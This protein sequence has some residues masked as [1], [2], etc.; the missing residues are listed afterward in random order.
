MA[1]RSIFRIVAALSLVLGLSGVSARAFAQ[2]GDSGAITGYVFDQAGNP[3]QRRENHRD[4]SHPDRRAED[5]L[6]QP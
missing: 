3:L 4:L 5:D 6:L 2:G 1:P